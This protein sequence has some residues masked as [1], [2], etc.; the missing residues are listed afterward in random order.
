MADRQIVVQ[1]G[2]LQ[3]EDEEWPPALG[4][5]AQLVHSGTIWLSEAGLETTRV[6]LVAEG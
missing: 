4:R 6:S 3:R 2:V 1:T 5:K